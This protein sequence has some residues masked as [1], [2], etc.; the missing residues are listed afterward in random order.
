[1]KRLIT[2]VL[3]SVPL[4]TAS[5]QAFAYPPFDSTDAAVADVNELE[6]EFGPAGYRRSQDEHTLIAPAYV[7]NYGFTKDW[8]LV[9]EEKASIHWRRLT[10]Y[11]ADLSATRCFSRA[12]E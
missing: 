6:I 4:I 3:V 2:S 5:Q 12:A 9:L 8:E 11:L 10:T 1:M 7:I